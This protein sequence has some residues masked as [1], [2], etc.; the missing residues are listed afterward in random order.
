MKWLPFTSVVLLAVSGSAQSLRQILLRAD[1]NLKD[2]RIIP[3]KA[4]PELFIAILAAEN[5]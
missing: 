3:C 4:S 2:V 1:S 5:H